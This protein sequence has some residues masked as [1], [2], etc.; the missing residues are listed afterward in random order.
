M[1]SNKNQCVGQIE[2]RFPP[3]C[4]EHSLDVSEASSEGSLT[5]GASRLLTTG[6]CRSQLH[7]LR[8]MAY[9]MQPSLR[10]KE[11]A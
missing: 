7:A 3:P 6:E 8:G 1:A 4:S 10:S 2:R 5:P 9:F 11:P